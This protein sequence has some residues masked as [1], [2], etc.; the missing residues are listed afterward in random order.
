M[1]SEEEGSR[2]RKKLISR[3]LQLTLVVDFVAMLQVPLGPVKRLI[4][5]VNWVLLNISSYVNAASISCQ[6]SRRR[7]SAHLSWLKMSGNPV[8]KVTVHSQ[9]MDAVEGPSTYS[10]CKN[11]GVFW[12]NTEQTLGLWG[13]HKGIMVRK[14]RARVGICPQ[15]SLT[16]VKEM[17]E[18]T[19]CHFFYLKR[20]N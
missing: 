5:Y 9:Q 6:T 16:E 2:G 1:D 14:L 8:F 3:D 17:I 15:L 20:K 12:V 10:F 4:N 19:Q 11:W 18:I 13:S 7:H